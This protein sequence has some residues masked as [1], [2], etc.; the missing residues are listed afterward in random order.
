M[1][2]F[3]KKEYDKVTIHRGPM[4][5][6]GVYVLV[7]VFG[8]LALLVASLS[9]LTIENTLIKVLATIGLDAVVVAICFAIFFFAKKQFHK[10]TVEITPEKLSYN[11]GHGKTKEIMLADVE[12]IVINPKKQSGLTSYDIEVNF[13]VAGKSVIKIDNLSD[14]TEC[15]LW[16]MK[17]RGIP[18]QQNLGVK[19]VDSYSFNPFRTDILEP[20][21]VSYY[22]DE[23]KVFFDHLQEK[24]ADLNMKC[25]VFSPSKGGQGPVYLCEIISMRSGLNMVLPLC[26][27]WM[28]KNIWAY[29]YKEFVELEYEPKLKKYDD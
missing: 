24:Y 14:A 3:Y 11:C 2:A 21:Q 8:G 5:L 9:C 10:I 22:I 4:A 23:A 7:L 25:T 6:I 17:K 1:K 13:V 26:D 16:E 29:N 28:G 18:M 15:L 27:K 19:G 20:D 12:C